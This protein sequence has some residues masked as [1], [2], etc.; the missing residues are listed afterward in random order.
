[1]ITVANNVF[2][3]QTEN[4]S[5]LFEV[6]KFKHLSALHYG[7]KVA[8]G[9]FEALRHK[10]T[11]MTGSSIAYDPTDDF[12]CLDTTLL[13]YSGIGAGDFRHSPAEI[14]MPDGTFVCDFTYVSHKIVEGCISGELPGAYGTDAQTLVVTLQDVVN[15]VE[16]TLHY[17]VFEKTNVFARRA[18]LTNNNQKKL[19]IRKLMSA[20]L[21]LGAGDYQLTTFDGGWIKETHKHTR[22]IDYGIY[23]NDSTT[24]GSS[25]RH[26]PG[27]LISRGKVCEDFGE[28]YGLNLIYSGN[29]YTAVEKHNN[30]T[31][32][33]MTGMN[34]HCFM[35]DLGFGESFETPQA[36]FTYS[37]GGYNGLS[38]NF[39]EFINNHIVSGKFKEAERP[40]LYNSWE[41]CFFNFNQRKLLSLA[42]K[43]AKLG[44]EL[45]VLDDGWFGARNSDKAGLG[46]YTVNKKK[47]PGGLNTLAK[48]INRL[49][50][51][52]G[53]WFEPE[54]VN[55]DSHLFR[56]HPDYVVK[57]SSRKGCLGRNQ[58]VLDLCNKNVRDYIVTNVNN[59]L[60]SANITYVKWDM[61]RHMSHMYSAHV[62]HQGQ[63]FHSYCLGLYDILKRIVD[64]N[65][66][67]LFESCSSGGNRFDL[68]MLCFMPQV[69]ASDDTDPI[70]R[71]AIQEGLSYL[72]P[73]STMGAHVSLA[74]HQQTLRKTPLYTRFNVAAF[75]QLGYELDLSFLS[76]VERKEIQKQIAFYKQHRKTLT[77]GTFFRY[78]RERDNRINFLCCG[79]ENA[80]LGNFQTLATASPGGDT[81]CVKGLKP[82]DCYTFETFPQGISIKRFGALINHISPI[83]L[84][85]E[86]FILRTINKH[87]MLPD[88]VESYKVTG[89]ALASGVKLANQFMGTYYNQ[90]TRLLGDFGSNL[91]TIQ[92]QHCSF[93]SNCVNEL[94]ER[95]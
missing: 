34:P 52:F 12:Y 26:N 83:K 95:R 51:E 93:I 45:F 25:N 21:D 41:G 5:Y 16:L 66:D 68:G 56:T 10:Q 48:K 29:H 15:N 62:N 22:K 71:L 85:P 63:F 28:V 23:V 60:A 13:E 55:E 49:G 40:V 94:H 35:W 70:E 6:T 90:N 88:C 1:M 78:D 17:T 59:T 75:G 32:R 33:V 36:I 69:W 14:L 87:Y 73:L 54:C 58:Y 38:Q 80:I 3:L 19:T 50:L 77:Q 46:D 84:H 31:L 57:I 89:A 27:I 37:S 74:P 42:R 39:H 8:D 81:V 9:D 65:P 86:G 4:T 11:A 91:Y 43:A 67:V 76:R 92:K 44:V 61:N 53:L 18:I 79:G 24:G 64:A 30:D 47:L 82:K 7:R 20:M 2:H 72:Y